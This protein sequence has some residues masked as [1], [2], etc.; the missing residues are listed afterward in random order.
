MTSNRGIA[1]LA[2]VMTTACDSSTAN[3]S[4]LLQIILALS[5][6]IIPQVQL[7]AARYLTDQ[8]HRLIIGYYCHYY[9][10]YG[11]DL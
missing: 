10:Q 6:S 11:Q 5:I 1:S 8:H 4:K 3:I 9:F 2:T 7:R